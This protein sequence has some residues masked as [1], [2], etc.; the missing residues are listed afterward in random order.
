MCVCVCVCVCV[1]ACVYVCVPVSI[2]L[3]LTRSSLPASWFSAIQQTGATIAF[4][5]T[6]GGAV[7]SPPPHLRAY[8]Y[9]AACT[10]PLPVQLQRLCEPP[11]CPYVCAQLSAQL[12]DA[13]D[14]AGL[15]QHGV[16]QLYNYGGL[17]TS[18]S[19]MNAAQ[20]VKCAVS[21]C[22]YLM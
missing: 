8:K 7:R 2:Y 16:T 21:C 4:D 5:A 18:P 17:D 13:I 9:T 11:M 19:T 3:S 10:S 14:S 12:I 15:S 6:G 20:K 1:P 22:S